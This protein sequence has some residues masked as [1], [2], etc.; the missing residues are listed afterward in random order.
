MERGRGVGV[1]V[2][3]RGGGEGWSGGV[4]EDVSED[5]TRMGMD[6][7]LVKPAKWLAATSGDVTFWRVWSL[8]F[9]LL[10]FSGI[11]GRKGCKKGGEV[12]RVTEGGVCGRESLW[13]GEEEASENRRKFPT[14]SK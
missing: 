7:H 3:G 1:G 9:L 4:E 12:A 8:P 13:E 6:S 2:E 10:L 14:A 5:V 11:W